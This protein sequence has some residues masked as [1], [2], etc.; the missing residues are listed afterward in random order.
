MESV[1]FRQVEG[2]TSRRGD[3]EIVASF[4]TRKHGIFQFAYDSERYRQLTDEPKMMM[5]SVSDRKYIKQVCAICWKIIF[6]GK[7]LDFDS[8]K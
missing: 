5:F 3:R 7:K 2:Y 1:T 6:D 8:M 4:N